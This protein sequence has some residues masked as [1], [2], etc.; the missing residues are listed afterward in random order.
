MSEECQAIFK[1]IDTDGDGSLSEAELKVVSTRAMH[2]QALL[3][4]PDDQI[5]GDEAADALGA[6]DKNEDGGV[7]EAEW[8]API[9]ASR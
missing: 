1:R 2:S 3:L 7:D 9:S 8:C 5:F 4:V 6:F